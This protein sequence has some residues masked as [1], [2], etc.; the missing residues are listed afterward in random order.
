MLN[1]KEL[2]LKYLWPSLNHHIRTDGV[3]GSLGIVLMVGHEVVLVGPP[4]GVV[5]GDPMVVTGVGNMRVMIRA[6]MII[7]VVGMVVVT[8]RTMAVMVTMTTI[9]VVVVVADMATNVLHHPE[10]VAL[11]ELVVV[12]HHVEVHGVVVVTQAEVV[13]EVE[14]GEDPEVLHPVVEGEDLQDVADPEEAVL[15]LV[16]GSM[17][18]TRRKH[19][20][21]ILN[22]SAGSWGRA[23]VVVG[24]ASQLLS[25]HCMIVMVAI[26]QTKIGTLTVTAS[27]G[28]QGKKI[29]FT[30]NF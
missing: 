28:S 20:W 12:V 14:E 18:Q 11:L 7:M 19:L 26:S 6:T 8:E 5:V 29:L 9:M 17:V 3:E 23:K 2:N 25:S 16:R 27:S 22:K 15:P 1:L 13:I 10:V 21:S 30:A 4:L 24:E